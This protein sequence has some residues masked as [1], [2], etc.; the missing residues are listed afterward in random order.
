MMDFEKMARPFLKDVKPYKPGRPLEEVR[1]ENQTITEFI[2]LASNE[3]PRPP[4]EFVQK[5]IIDMLSQVNRYPE[6]G[7]YD[8]VMELAKVHQVN[9]D[10]VFVG[11]GSNEIIDLLVR[12]FVFPGENV[13]FPW[14]S[15]VIYMLVPKICDVQGI[16]VPC[17]DYRVD[18][19]AMR[20]AVNDKTKMVF[21]CNPNNPTSTYVSNDEFMRF[22]GSLPDNILVVMDEAYYEYVSAND[23]PQTIEMQKKHDCLITLRTFSKVHS[24]AG[25]RIGY[26][27]SHRKVVELLHKVRQPFNVNRLAQ[28]AALAALKCMDKNVPSIEETQK[29]REML[30]EAILKVGWECPPSQTNFLYVIPR[31]FPGDVCE[32]LLQKGIIIRD[33]TPFG[34]EKNTFRLTVGLPEENRKFLEALDGVLAA[35]S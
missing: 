33:M 5:A 15:F 13:V 8:L 7:C 26:A 31:N 20:E 32:P 10:E 9:P 4:H 1:R 27:I 21:V 3:N 24:L 22:L 18:L 34:A 12:A 11:N 29:E 28:T 14:P 17:F 23:F 30:R 19:A 2:K 25:L 16:S 35:Q 6:S